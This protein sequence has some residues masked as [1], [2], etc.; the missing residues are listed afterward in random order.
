MRVIIT[1]GAGL[2]G[3]ALTKNL[4]ADGYEVIILSRAPERVNNLPPG[5]S[6]VA[7]DG[8]T[9]AGW[10]HLA[11]G[12]EAICRISPSPSMSMSSP[13]PISFSWAGAGAS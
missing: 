4:T 7:W 11:D 1:G 9:A 5:V 8:R 10:G 2:I 6:A 13:S 12:V 3:R